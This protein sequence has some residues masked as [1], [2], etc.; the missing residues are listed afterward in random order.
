[1]AKRGTIR[2]VAKAAAVSATTVSRWLNGS[3][4]LPPQTADRLRLA[5][6]QI[7]YEANP[8][9]RRLSLGRADMLALVVPDIANPFFAQLA[10]AI[11][12]AADALGLGVV[13]YS[14][15]NRPGRELA[16]FDRLRQNYVDGLLFLTNHSDDGALRRC[17]DNQSAIVLLDE[18]VPGTHVHKVFADND[19]G[20]QMAARHLIAAGHRDC[21]FV[22][23]PRDVMSAI[24]RHR[25]FQSAFVEAGFA[26]RDEC[27]R[28][29]GY[30]SAHGRDAAAFLLGLD[31]RPTAVFAAADEIA[32]GLLETFHSQGIS[33]PGTM[34]L[35]AFD[36]VSPLRLFHPPLTA[37]AQPVRE[38]GRV[39]VA[40]LVDQIRGKELPIGTLRLPVTLEIRESV[41]TPACGA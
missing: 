21:A 17:I 27:V 29:G 37:I 22:G 11:E 15:L 38:M 13:L 24:E 26:L 3:I 1:M 12:E 6:H 35:V 2:D 40:R 4:S 33:V 8:H 23:G 34:S 18:D 7:G 19:G 39:G 28:F 41:G 36:D 10:S 14:T 9:A 16:T 30:S 31:R 20:G 32:L 5:I 25:G